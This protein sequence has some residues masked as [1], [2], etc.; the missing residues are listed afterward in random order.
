MIIAII[1]VRKWMISKG[2]DN[3][4]HSCSLVQVPFCVC[5]QVFTNFFDTT[6]GPKTDSES[7]KKIAA[8][9]KSPAEEILFLTDLPEGM[10]CIFELHESKEWILVCNHDTNFEFVFSCML[11][12]CNAKFGPKLKKKITLLLIWAVKCKAHGYNFGGKYC[13][14]V[15]KLTLIFA[16]FTSGGI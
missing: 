7:Y 11:N 16:E 6:I 2:N 1:L 5:F 12:T 4:N 14:I 3:C 9:I 15:W 10:C 8:E 13:F